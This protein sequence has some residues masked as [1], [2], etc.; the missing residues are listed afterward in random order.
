MADGSG[1]PRPSLRIETVNFDCSDAEAMAGFYGKLLGWES[2]T[3]TGR[4]P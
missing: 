1:E 4:S 3:A 2:R